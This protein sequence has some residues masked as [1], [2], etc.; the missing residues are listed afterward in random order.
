MRSPANSILR[1]AL[2]ALLLL[3]PPRAQAQAPVTPSFPE[4]APTP[5]SVYVAVYVNGVAKLNEAAGT[6]EGNLDV[7]LRWRDQRLAFNSKSAGT[8]RQEFSKEAAAAK[9]ATI[10]TPQVAITNLADKAARIEAGLFVYA[11][12]S[13]V[14]F[15]RL[16]AVFETPYRLAGFPFDTQDLTVRLISTTYDQDQI[17][18]A[19]D[20]RDL[21]SSGVRDGLVIAGWT[22]LRLDFASATTRAWNG[23]MLPAIEARLLVRRHASA[24]LFS[25][26]LPFLSVLFI[27]T[28]LTLYARTDAASRLATWSGAILALVALNFTFSL[29][30]PYL[31]NGSL[32]AEIVTIGFAYELM[33]VAVTI[34]VLNP[35]VAD[36][37]SNPY[38]MPEVL[39]FLRWSVP[40]GLV[41]LLVTRAL[42]TAL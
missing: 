35:Q 33:M 12:G 14:F 42:L 37:L 19:Q 22:P 30:Y 23:D 13:V 20:Q 5:L 26:L 1:L 17:R 15:Q 29:R 10:W 34:T 18:F 41:V 4:N 38:V 2:L 27:P 31:G 24:H 3:C 11:D 6:F 25:I 39:S 7:Q 36:K 40:L 28:L 32:V 8:D 16:Q 9:L 21:H